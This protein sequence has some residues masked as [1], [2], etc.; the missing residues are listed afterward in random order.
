L[1]EAEWKWASSWIVS[2]CHLGSFDLC[3]QILS[4]AS[5]SVS[6]WR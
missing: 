1:L 6:L 5:C 2:P 4:D 3:G